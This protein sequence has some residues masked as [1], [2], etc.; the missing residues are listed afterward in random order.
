MLIKPENAA[1]LGMH[2]KLD[3]WMLLSPWPW[4]PQK[5]GAIQNLSETVL[6]RLT[7][8]LKTCDPDHVP[9]PCIHTCAPNAINGTSL[10][11]EIGGRTGVCHSHLKYFMVK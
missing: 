7:S 8:M 9:D 2:K 3:V 11:C 5:H 6:L 4:C 1:K 10:M